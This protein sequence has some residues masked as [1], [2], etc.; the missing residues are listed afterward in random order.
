MIASAV[1]PFRMGEMA[2]CDVLLCHSQPS[3]WLGYRA[4][5]LFGT[6]YVGYLH[7]LTTFIHKR[8]EAAGNW[9]TKGDFLVLDGLLGVFGRPIAKHLDRLCHKDASRLLFNS[10]WTKSL[11][12]QEY[13]LSGDVC[14]PG[15]EVPSSRSE[16]LRQNIVVTASRHYPWKRIDLAFHVLKR[17]KAEPLL[18]VAGEETS[19]TATLREIASELSVANR[20]AFTGFIDDQELFSIFARAK[21]YIQTS[22]REPFGLGPLEAQSYGTPAV[23]WGDA[24]VRET[25]LDRETGF[26][27][28]PY[29]VGDF[30]S[31]LELI[32]SNDPRRSEMSRAAQIWASTFSWEAHVDILEG[33]LDEEKR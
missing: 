8:P 31:K 14:Y 27:A 30:A 12:E 32:L 1:I 5:L 3:M 2:D 7:Q 21:A 18:V 33:I 23:V 26:H 25:V 19:H 10:A 15:I 6:P 28:T 4:N 20:V 24:G 29:D 11:F 13:G 16:P 22:V 9:A 17:L